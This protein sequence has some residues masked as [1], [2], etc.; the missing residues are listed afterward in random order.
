MEFIPS[1]KGKLLLVYEGYLYKKDRN[2]EEKTYWKC[3]DDECRGRA[4]TTGVPPDAE[5]CRVTKEHSHAPD[6]TLIEVS[7]CLAFCC[8][9]II[10]QV[11]YLSQ[12]YDK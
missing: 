11:Y 12:I 9:F 3:T 1:Q 10:N 2:R 4:V 8:P 5:E 7:Q 6:S